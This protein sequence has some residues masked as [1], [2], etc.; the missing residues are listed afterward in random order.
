[1]CL[2]SLFF[3]SFLTQHLHFR[4]DKFIVIRYHKAV[5][6]FTCLLAVKE[7]NTYNVISLPLSL[8]RDVPRIQKNSGARSLGTKALGIR[9]SGRRPHLGATAVVPF[10]E[11]G[12]ALGFRASASFRIVSHQSSWPQ[13]KILTLI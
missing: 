8:P 6:T 4:A 5:G 7:S 13:Y 10:L 3:R 9:P 11:K 1:M 12:W 2:N